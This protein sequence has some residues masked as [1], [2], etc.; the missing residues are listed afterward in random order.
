[1]D[2]LAQFG[3]FGNLSATGCYLYGM[4]IALMSAC[5]ALNLKPPEKED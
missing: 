3:Y 2:M 4:V 1:M 5:L